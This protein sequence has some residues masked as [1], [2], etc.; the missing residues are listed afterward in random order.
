[1]I[2][3][4]DSVR[5]KSFS[6][7]CRRTQ[8]FVYQVVFGSGSEQTEIYVQNVKENGPVVPP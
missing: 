7:N 2:F 1:M 4:K 8:L 3:G 5:I 6:C